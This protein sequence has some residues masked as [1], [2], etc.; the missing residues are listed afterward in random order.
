MEA[1]I[2]GWSKPEHIIRKVPAAPQNTA[3]CRRRID[4]G[5]LAPGQSQ[6]PVH[7]GRKRWRRSEAFDALVALAEFLAIPVIDAPGAAVANFPKSHDLYLGLDAAPYFDEMDVALLVENEAPWYPP[8]K[9]PKNARIVSISSNPLKDV[10]V[11][12]SDRRRAS[13]KAIP[14][15]RFGCSSWRRCARPAAMPPQ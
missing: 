13:P 7:P 10:L 14:P 5:R 2:E 4:A 15:S 11:Y 6:V 9:T 8:S 3:C 1:M 12:Q